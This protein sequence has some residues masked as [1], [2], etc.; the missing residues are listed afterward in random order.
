MYVHICVQC[1]TIFFFFLSCNKTKLPQ[2]CF[3][4]YVQR[5]LYIWCFLI[6][7]GLASTA[8]F[9]IP[10]P[11]KVWIRR[12]NSMGICSICVS[13]V[14]RCGPVESLSWRSARRRFTSSAHPSTSLALSETRSNT[15]QLIMTAVTMVGW[16]G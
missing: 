10:Y 3:S 5:K 12:Y 15:P 8:C 4:F 11:Y 1:A 16:R 2:T 9:I 6:S 7:R 14:F 13:S